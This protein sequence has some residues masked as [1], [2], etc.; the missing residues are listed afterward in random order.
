VLEEGPD[1]RDG[2]DRRRDQGTAQ[3]K[4]ERSEQRWRRDWS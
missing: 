3:R 4:S 1:L 2:E